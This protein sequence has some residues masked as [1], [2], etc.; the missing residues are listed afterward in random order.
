MEKIVL[1]PDLSCKHCVMKV[2]PVLKNEPGIIDYSIDLEHSDKL[3]TLSSDGANIDS[4]ITKF[5]EKGY[6]AQ[7]V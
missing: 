2:E 5:K 1:K 6:S 4:L 3:V 7:K